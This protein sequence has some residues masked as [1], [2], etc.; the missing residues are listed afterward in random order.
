MEPSIIIALVSL[1]GTIVTVLFQFRKE[2]LAIKKEQAEIKEES[3]NNSDKTAIEAVGS[4]ADIVLRMHKQE[5]DTLRQIAEDLKLRNKYLEEEL[6]NCQ[7]GRKDERK[8]INA[9]EEDLRRCSKDNSIAKNK[10]DELLKI[11]NCEIDENGNIIPK[12][13]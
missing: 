8:V 5:I 11:V 6:T 4:I 7:L 10:I 2:K 13:E 12:T 1:I 9:I 3:K